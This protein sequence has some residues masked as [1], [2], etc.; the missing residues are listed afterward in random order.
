MSGQN[1]GYFNVTAV[2][3]YIYLPLCFE[4]LDTVS[5]INQLVSRGAGHS[6]YTR[7]AN[8]IELGLMAVTYC[9]STAMKAGIY[10]LQALGSC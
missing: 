3:R 10:I 8:G 5:C 6:E 9:G 1:V 7:P 4:G 2:C